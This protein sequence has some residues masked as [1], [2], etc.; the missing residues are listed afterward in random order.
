MRSFHE[1][2]LECAAQHNHVLR[3]HICAPTLG[4][5]IPWEHGSSYSRSHGVDLSGKWRVRQKTRAC[6]MTYEFT[7]GTGKPERRNHDPR[8]FHLRRS[9]GI[10]ESFGS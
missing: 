3:T 10:V 5:L 4:A 7:Q 2:G 9:R 8:S 6:R 1:P